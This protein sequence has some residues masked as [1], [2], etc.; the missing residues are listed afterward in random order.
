MGAWRK[1]AWGLLGVL[2]VGSVVLFTARVSRRGRFSAPFSTYGAGPEGTRA[3][4]RLV[5]ELGREPAR[6]S[7]EIG[8]LG[9]GTLIAVAGCDG[10]QVRPLLRPEREEL[11]RWVEAGGLLIVAGAEHYLP[12]SS[13]LWFDRRADCRDAEKDSWLEGLLNGPGDD[14][15]ALPQ[16]ILALPFG[17][18]LAHALPFQTK[19]ARTL[20][21]GIESQATELISSQY[22]PLGLTSPFGRG[23]VVLLGIPESLS[24]RRLAEGGGVVIARLLAAFAPEGQVWFDEYHLG[25]GERR[26]LIRYL[27]EQGYGLVLLQAVLV[28]LALLL[29]KTARVGRPRE[30]LRSPTHPLTARPQRGKSYLQAL[31]RMYEQSQDQSGALR[32]LARHAL[33]RLGRRYRAAGVEPER[34]ADWLERAGY[35]SVAS[36]ARKIEDHAERPLERGE[37]LVARARKIEE[38]FT[39]AVALGDTT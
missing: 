2:F 36:C 27:R 21:S 5:E 17:A 4:Y 13:G 23:R 35:A 11:A 15:D 16:D 24:N 32:V 10:S 6:L 20:R 28:V 34:M 22:G 30:A 26:S 12:E 19:R 14:A 3:L 38:D 18:P 9:R 7:H 1:L 25:M 29:A 8:H 31:S 37:S 39:F 33:V